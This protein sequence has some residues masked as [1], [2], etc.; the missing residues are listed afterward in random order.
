M[1]GIDKIAQ[2]VAQHLDKGDKGS[3]IDGELDGQRDE[4][5]QVTI[6]LAEEDEHGLIE[7]MDIAERRFLRGLPLVMDDVV[8]QVPV[9]PTAL[10]Q[11][12]RQ[13]T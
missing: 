7:H 9:L 10:Q 2:T 8:R 5:A 4:D 3:E 13:V 6:V 1:T 12:I 11:P